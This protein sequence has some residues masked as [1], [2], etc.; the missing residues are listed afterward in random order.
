MEAA[1]SEAMRENPLLWNRSLQDFSD[2]R[3]K[4]AQ[5]SK[6]VAFE[7]GKEGEGAYHFCSSHSLGIVCELSDG[8]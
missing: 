5:V 2:S 6:E 1:L 4:K 8:L 7:L 3:G